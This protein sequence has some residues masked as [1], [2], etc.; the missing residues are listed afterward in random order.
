MGA[1]LRDS[2]PQVPWDA[3]PEQAVGVATVVEDE[4]VTVHSCNAGEHEEWW[5]FNFGDQCVPVGGVSLQPSEHLRYLEA[6][7]GYLVLCGLSSSAGL[8]DWGWSL[9]FFPEMS[10]SVGWWG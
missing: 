7:R 2:A 10:S 8:R 1:S 4:D 6:F 3:L 9:G 5:F